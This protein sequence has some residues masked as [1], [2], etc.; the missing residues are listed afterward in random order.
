MRYT[1]D[2][3]QKILNKQSEEYNPEAVKQFIINCLAEKA[4][5][6]TNT[7]APTYKALIRVQGYVRNLKSI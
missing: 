7:E 1:N 4:N 2:L 6:C 3:L 5:K